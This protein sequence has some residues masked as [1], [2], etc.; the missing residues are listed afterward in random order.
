[1][2]HRG[3]LPSGFSGVGAKHGRFKSYFAPDFAYLNSV[4]GH[5]MSSGEAKSD[6]LIAIKHSEERAVFYLREAGCLVKRNRLRR[7]RFR[8]AKGLSLHTD[9][10]CLVDEFINLVNLSSSGLAPQVYGYGYRRVFGALLEEYIFTEFLDGAQSLDDQLVSGDLSP[11]QALLSVI[12][13]FSKMIDEGFCHLDS[14]PGNIMVMPGGDLKFI[15]FEGCAFGVPERYFSLAFCLGRFYR[16]W[17]HRYMSEVEYDEVVFSF[18]CS[19]DLDEAFRA[20]YERFKRERISR[21][22]VNRCFSDKGV[23]ELFIKESTANDDFSRQSST[24]E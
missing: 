11:Q 8:Y 22:R 20:V 6:G 12:S 10:N 23:R 13:L 1:M 19:S 16:F 3:R 15:D 9:K 2:F 17:F 24:A 4:L 21:R 5:F 14:H 7:W 18:A